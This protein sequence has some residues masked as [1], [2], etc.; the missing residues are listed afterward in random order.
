M[1]LIQLF[2]GVM[3][4]TVSVLL[5]AQS[6]VEQTLTVSVEQPDLD[7]SPY[8]R[9]YIAIWLETD[10]RKGVVTLALWREQS[11]WLKDLRQWWRKLGRKG[12]AKGEYFLSPYEET[13]NEEAQNE[14]AQNDGVTGATRKPGKYTLEFN[15]ANHQLAP[16]DYYLNIEAS[17]EEGGRDYLRQKI[18]LGSGQVTVE[19]QGKGELGLV[20]VSVQ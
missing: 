8:H 14:E 19:K 13:Q 10:K 12:Y 6:T 11:D 9:P 20:L 18:T 4:L 15:L 2:I 5:S 17:R 16:G 3:A 1:K 7:V